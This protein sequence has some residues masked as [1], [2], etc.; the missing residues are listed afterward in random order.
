[1]LRLQLLKLHQPDRCT[2]PP[3]VPGADIRRFLASLGGSSLYPRPPFSV[4]ALSLAGAIDSWLDFSNS[5]VSKALAQWHDAGSE[6]ASLFLLHV[7]RM[8]LTDHSVQSEHTVISNA[9]TLDV[10]R[11]PVCIVETS[12]PWPALPALLNGRTVCKV[13]TSK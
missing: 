11:A 10:Q 12:A 13:V 4:A 5:S 3:T 1:M 2:I 8:P 6:K 9:R 7:T